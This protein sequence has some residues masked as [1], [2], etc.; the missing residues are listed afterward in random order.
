M[1]Y[2]AE[3]M[4]TAPVTSGVEFAGTIKK[5]VADEFRKIDRTVN[6][7][8]TQYFDHAFAP[9]IVLRWD[10]QAVSRY[11]FLRA[12]DPGQWLEE[13]RVLLADSHPLVLSLDTGRDGTDQSFGSQVEEEARGLDT[14]VMGVD[15]TVDL[16]AES[17]QDTAVRLLGQGLLQGGRGA[18]D[19]KFVESASQDV[20]QGFAGAEVGDVS[21]TS[22]LLETV[23]E[24]L[25][26]TEAARMS[27][28]VR[29]IWEGHGQDRGRFP[30]GDTL[31][32]LGDEDLRY[33]VT[34]LEDAD[35]VFWARVAHSVEMDQ[36]VRVGGGG[37][38][39]LD[40]LDS[41]QA[42]VRSRV[43]NLRAKAVRASRQQPG[44][45]E[46][47]DEPRWRVNGG[48]LN[49]ESPRAHFYLASR[50]G[51]ELP[52]LKE[53]STAQSS[54]LK[55][56]PLSNFSTFRGRR[57]DL[58]SDITMIELDQ[59][60]DMTVTFD[61]RASGSAFEDSAIEAVITSS[62]R[63]RKV[64]TTCD[65]T[66]VE[67]DFRTH[68]LSTRTSGRASLAPMIEVAAVLLVNL[69]KEARERL[70][71]FLSNNESTE[72]A[73][74]PQMVIPDVPISEEEGSGSAQD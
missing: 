12:G 53:P 61:S 10:S 41:F 47:I 27:R 71:A 2:L 64:A 4:R 16:S 6:V 30:G 62:S 56:D 49:L 35:E 52:T 65:G 36:L 25:Q 58:R 44:I 66:E 26:G 23:S 28:V 21:S 60:S 43:H 42:L 67:A 54:V 34:S 22:K 63:V 51:N 33:L 3:F 74:G 1:T 69:P 15:A 48:V 29:A 38:T 45:F 40:A 14:L 50:S 24:S 19:Q 8:A 68:T 55:K 17:T 70:E 7:F 11:V 72:A 20:R 13:D 18:A 73:E 46:E 31:G 37:P 5:F 9:D 32:P 57:K 39:H 59:G